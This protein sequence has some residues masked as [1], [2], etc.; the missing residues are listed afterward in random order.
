MKKEI[1]AAARGLFSLLVG[2]GHTKKNP[3]VLLEPVRVYSVTE[4]PGKYEYRFPF[5]VEKL[6]AENGTVVLSGMNNVRQEYDHGRQSPKLEWERTDR[7]VFDEDYLDDNVGICYGELF[8]WDLAALLLSLVWTK[9]FEGDY[10]SIETSIDG[11]RTIH[12]NGYLWHDEHWAHTEVS[13]F[14]MPLEEFIENYG[15]RG[16]EYVDEVYEEVKQYQQDFDSEDEALDCTKRYFNGRPAD[17]VLPFGL[18]T[19]DTP[20][21]HYVNPN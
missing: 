2:K 10:Y 15:K 3:L 4:N 17:A 16:S 18:L 21:G 8:Y 11:V 1:P 9:P 14:L 13:W 7:A 20:E 5:I 12:V 6:W 19:K